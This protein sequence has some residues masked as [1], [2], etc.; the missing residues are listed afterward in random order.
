MKDSN[1]TISSNKTPRYKKD[2]KSEGKGHGNGT[3]NNYVPVAA[4][5]LMLLLVVSSIFVVNILFYGNIQNKVKALR[6][7]ASMLASTINDPVDPRAGARYWVDAGL[8]NS[9]RL[10]TY[11]AM[12]EFFQEVDLKNVSL[13]QRELQADIFQSR[14]FSDSANKLALE[15]VN[16]ELSLKEKGI[17]AKG[18]SFEALFSITGELVN[19]TKDMEL[20]FS[21][22]V[23]LTAVINPS[24]E[25][26]MSDLRIKGIEL[27]NY[28]YQARAQISAAIS[29]LPAG[30]VNILAPFVLIT[31]LYVAF[32]LFPWILLLLFFLRKRKRLVEAKTKLIRDLNL[33][34]KFVKASDYVSGQAD[35]EQ[36]RLQLVNREIDKRAFRESEYLVSLGLLTLI[37]ATLLYFFFYPNASSGLAQLISTGGGVKAFANY[38]ASDATPI[39]FGFIG[40]Y[41]FIIQMLLRRYFAADLSPNV[42]NYAVVRVLTVFILS[43]VLQFATTSFGWPPYVAASVAFVVGIFP[44]VGLRWILRTANK[45]LTGLKAPEFIDRYPLTELDGLNT[46]HEARLMEEKIENIHNLATT[47]LDDLIIN[48]NFCPLQ[49]I[50][51]VD[52]ALLFIYVQEEWRAAFLL[53]GIRTATDFLDNTSSKDG[54]RTEKA[55]K[56][57]VALTTALNILSSNGEQANSQIVEAVQKSG[58]LP[59]MKIE[60]LETMYNSLKK[61]PNVKE[62]ESFWMNYGKKKIPFIKKTKPAL[63]LSDKGDAPPQ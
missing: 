38:L 41:F 55:E 50:D 40:T 12:A 3:K 33:I 32:L 37:N 46:W 34:N 20:A 9:R 56:L 11:F 23:K 57:C 58:A 60:F 8:E 63:N 22:L 31:V 27:T 30:D 18:T 1:V 28:Y 21:E 4:I 52:Q 26:E 59:E 48:T 13:I 6:G 62:L 24:S 17:E 25:T 54:F 51:W 47:S 39:T 43:M 42:Y 29:A 35:S 14:H 49:L 16:Q 5:L 36:E 19:T 53:T 45:L 61:G 2:G 10:N 7:T 15:L 44:R